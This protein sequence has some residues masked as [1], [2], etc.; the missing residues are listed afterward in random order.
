MLEAALQI[1]SD[2][3][4]RSTDEIFVDVQRRGL[5]EPHEAR[6]SLYNSLHGYILRAIAVGHK[7]HLADDPDY[8]FHLNRPLDD[9][10][11]IDTTGLPP[12]AVSSEP[13][14]SAAAAVGTLRAAAAGSDPVA[15]ERVVCASF[16]L[17]GFAATHLGGHDAPDGYA[18]APLG[19]LGYRTLIECKLEASPSISN[20]IAVVEAARYRQAY[21]ASYSALVAPAFDSEINFAS[22]LRTHSVTAWTV[23]DLI[24][25]ATLRLDCSR[26]RQLFASGF[27]AEK[28][29]DIEWESVHG[30]PK[31]LRVVASLLIEIGLQQQRM[32]LT[33]A[34]G[35]STPRLTTDVALSTIDDRL[36]AAGSTHG[37]TREEI[38][39][40]FT[41]LTSAYVGRALW[42]DDSRTAIVIRPQLV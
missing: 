1:L 28:L 8:R 21:R 9:W 16:E 10:P 39:A 40:A 4:P 24:S 34:D 7:P 36:T 14:P 30:A 35:M 23:D 25:A 19:E 32:A 31:R 26:V 5:P 17:L 12:L 42:S 20:S 6:R 27:A 29:D 33:L 41:W 22:E 37:V 11:A 38:D 3:K 18:D 15:F 13:P 2:G